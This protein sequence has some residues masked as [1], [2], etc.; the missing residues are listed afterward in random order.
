M[1]KL[2]VTARVIPEA[3]YNAAQASTPTGKKFLV[4]V[5]DPDESYYIG[6]LAHEIQAQY[7]RLYKQ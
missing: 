4:I 7:Q 2:K 3:A 5:R 1:V 6:T